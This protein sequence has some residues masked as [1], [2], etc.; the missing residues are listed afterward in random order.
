[1]AF[2]TE[3]A[4]PSRPRN[5]L[6]PRFSAISTGKYWQAGRTLPVRKD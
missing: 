3:T 6:L 5:N 1:M 4:N 2:L